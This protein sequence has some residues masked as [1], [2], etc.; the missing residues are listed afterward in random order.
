MIR[1]L[2]TNIVKNEE[3]KIM[4]IKTVFL[5]HHRVPVGLSERMYALEGQEH[6]EKQSL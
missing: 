6:M 3:K 1:L 4:Q 2:V 5:K